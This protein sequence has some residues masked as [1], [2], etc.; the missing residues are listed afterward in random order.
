L[1]LHLYCIIVSRLS[2]S[3]LAFIWS[4]L[5]WSLYVVHELCLFGRKVRDCGDDDDDDDDDGGDDDWRIAPR[6]YL[7]EQCDS[8]QHH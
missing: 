3:I 4:G 2:G 6:V 5:V 8:K 1:R 7:G